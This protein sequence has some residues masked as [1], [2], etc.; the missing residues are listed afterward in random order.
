L[1]WVLFFTVVAWGGI[2]GVAYFLGGPGAGAA[3]ADPDRGIIS[4]ALTV[5]YGFLLVIQLLCIYLTQSRG[6]WL[7]IGIGLALFAVALWLV[8]RRRRVNWMTR[9]GGTASALLL[10]GVLFVGVLN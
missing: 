4:S 8:G 6:P 1:L 9:I 7:G 10:A 5:S 3:S 2:T